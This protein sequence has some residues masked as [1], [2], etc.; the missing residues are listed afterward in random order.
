MPPSTPKSARTTTGCL[1]SGKKRLKQ[2]TLTSFFKKASASG[3]P[4]STVKAGKEPFASSNCGTPTKANELKLFIGDEDSVND[5]TYVTANDGDISMDLSL[6]R[7]TTSAQTQE[8]SEEKDGSNVSTVLDSDDTCRKSKRI[9][10]YAEDSGDEDEI[11]LGKR[12]KAKKRS[13]ADSD[14]DDDD[15]YVPDKLDS[16]EDDF[17]GILDDDENVDILQLGSK[18]QSTTLGKNRPAARTTKVQSSVGSGGAIK[19][20]KS[21]S[22]V[23]H[24]KFAKVNEER[25]QWLVDERDEDGR[26]PSDPD[27]N[28]RTLFIP[29]S[30]WASFTAFERQYWEI[31]SKM[32]DCI[33]FFKKGKFFELYEKDARLANQ[34]F[35]LKI[36]GGGRANMQLAGIP[37]MSFDYWASQFIQHG[38]KVGKVDQRESMLAKEMREGN[39]GI[40]KRELE[41]V[42]TSGTLTDIGML[43]SDMA[44]YCLAVRE[45]PIDFYTVEEGG[46]PLPASQ[47][48]GR[49]FGVAFVDT[50]T[51]HI[52]VLEFQDDL[53]CSQLDTLMAQV[54]PKEVIIE[55][56][57]LSAIAQKIVKFNS[58]P[59]SIFNNRSSEEFYDF[60]KTFDELTTHDY[61]PSMEEWPPV[62]TRYYEEGKKVGFHAFGG[63][64]SYLQWL[65]L[66]QSLIS[67]GQVSEYS[68][69]RS[70]V[71]LMLDGVT[72]QNLEIFANSFDGTD[73]GTLFKLLNRALTPMGKRAMRNWV[74]HPLLQKEQIESRFDSVDLLLNNMNL[75]SKIESAFTGL[76]DLERQLARIHSS[77]L[78]IK[79]FDKVISGF[80]RLSE[81]I[82]DLSKEELVGSLAAFV[83]TIPV[84]LSQDIEAWT[85]VYDRRRAIEEGCIILNKGIEPEFDDSIHKLDCLEEELNTVL[86]EYKKQFKCSSIKYKDSGKELYTIEMPISVCG[87]VPS[88]W[89]QM[90]SNKSTKRY[91]SPEVKA[92]ARSVAEA[93]ELHKVIEESLK[94]RL[95]EKFFAKYNTTW[96]PT[97]KAVADIDCILS[98]ALTSESLGFPACRPKFFDEI[99][100][101]TGEMLNGFVSFK[102][103]RHPCF[104]MGSN[105]AV[106]FIPNDIELGRN[107]AQIGLLTGANAAGK[108][109]VLRMTCV[110]V[111]LAQLGCY[112]PC[113]SAELTPID[114]I[115]T[116]LGANDNIIQG[117]STFFVELSETKR[118]LDMAT[119][120]S[121][122]VLD[123]LGRGG[124]SSDG[125]A[126]AEGVLHHIATHIQSL[127]FFATHYGGLGKSF[128]HHPMVKPLKMTILVD[129]ESR[130]VTFLYKLADGQSEGSF[131]MHVASMCGIPIEVVDNAEKAA[132]DFEHTSR[133]LKERKMYLK[134]THLIPLGLQSD[135]VRL[136]FGD[137]LKNNSKGTGEDVKNYTSN[138][139][140]KVLSTMISIIDGLNEE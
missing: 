82:E 21:E 25:Y 98:L 28:P 138:I 42:L 121:L 108:S 50:A 23:K 44:T 139:K 53:E 105:T 99:D 17:V 22:P 33:I 131:G 92:L 76:P 16:P 117:K 140:S 114:R 106:D 119:N 41:L 4:N 58:Q 116:R 127:G 128:E 73:K 60:E 13:A 15:I 97:I 122:L 34:L 100:E 31:K 77:S 32:W 59:D 123:E 10:S 91:Y 125:F 49:L 40:V 5:T 65:K 55:K 70:Q 68:P 74:M 95:Y 38:Y 132:D 30:A 93:R 48:M 35:D 88:N 109:T 136:C 111:I 90:G 102:E 24:K 12:R 37:E 85:Q 67:M 26:S 83:N 112:V 107:T 6:P 62:L 129:D 2:A 104:N 78:K 51:G 75:R 47:Q 66:D 120:R 14:D 18:T 80:E 94:S 115:M 69:A 130:K 64:L 11:P 20:L 87:K 19:R 72:L 63:L 54:K 56:R 27:Y 101:L 96:L 36:V 134:D 1:S 126:I 57:N 7:E 71:S 84:S 137:G 133:L 45:E 81:L 118:I 103:L 89:T 8:S 113:E 43:K 135:I 79:D 61:F 9:K 46:D 39:K 86:Q 52:N 29:D 110:A 124:S 3:T